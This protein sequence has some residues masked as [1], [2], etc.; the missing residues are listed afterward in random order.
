[1]NKLRDSVLALL[2]LTLAVGG[3]P[4]FPDPA[5]PQ[6]G[7]DADDPRVGQAAEFTNTFIHNV[8][9]TARIVDNC[10]IVIENFT[11]DGIG[12]DV[13]VVGIVDGDF[14]NFTILTS[15]IRRAGGYTDETLEVPL[16]EDVTLDDAPT[17]SIMCVPFSF[18]FGHATFQ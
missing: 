6:T 3:C 7:C 9:G 8:H 17:I 12:L 13:R 4:T 18:S 5:T 10:T 14:S 1:M 11:Y 2:V 15:D 16:P